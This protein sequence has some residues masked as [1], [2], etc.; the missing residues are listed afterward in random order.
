MQFKPEM[1]AILQINSSAKTP[2]LVVV[3]TNMF[4]GQKDPAEKR[5]MENWSQ[6]V[7]TLNATCVFLNR[8]YL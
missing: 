4:F 8:L 1:A 3:R 7:T 2:H 5:I 6:N